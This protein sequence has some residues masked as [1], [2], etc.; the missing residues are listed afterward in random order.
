MRVH[1]CIREEEEVRGVGVHQ[2]DQIGQGGAIDARFWVL[3]VRKLNLSP[4]G[5]RAGVLVAG[6]P[7]SE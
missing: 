4:C 7:W 5:G 6:E 2:C 1:G 3:I